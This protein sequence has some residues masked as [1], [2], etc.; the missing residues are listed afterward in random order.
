[1]TD[2]QT[3]TEWPTLLD[4]A[5]PDPDYTL[6]EHIV[7]PVTADV[8]H[9]AIGSL[10]LTDVRDPVTRAALWV[11]GLPERL[12]RRVPPRRPTRMTFDD[13]VIGTDWVLLGQRPGHEI[14]LGAAGRF[15][16]PVIQWI[17]VRPDEFAAFEKPGFGRIGIAFSVRPHG[18]H[19]SLVTY[20]VRTVPPDTATRRA[21]GRYWVTVR[22]V[23][24]GMLNA[25]RDTAVRQTVPEA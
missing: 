6:I 17:P 10:D 1:M 7:L 24:R 22:Q 11:R 20:E 8:A 25:I 12:G 16:T 23:S 9:D 2:Q 13:L 14:A 4:E 21:F 5:L 3:N 19:H 15:W 18:D